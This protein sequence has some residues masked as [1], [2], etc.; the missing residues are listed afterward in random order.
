MIAIPCNKCD[1]RALGCHG[2]CERYAEYKAAKIEQYELKKTIQRHTVGYERLIT[3][4]QR[5]KI[6]DRQRKGGKV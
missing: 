2:K 5:E 1:E 4:L 3:R 6:A